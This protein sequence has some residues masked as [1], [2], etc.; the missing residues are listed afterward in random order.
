MEKRVAQL[1]FVQAKQL[2]RISTDKSQFL[3]LGQW[4]GLN[5]LSALLHLYK[6]IINRIQYLT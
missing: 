2:N 6:W 5:P 4:K 1:V 3:K